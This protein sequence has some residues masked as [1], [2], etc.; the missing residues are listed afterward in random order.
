MEIKNCYD[1]IM[2]MEDLSNKLTS[3][4]E[5]NQSSGGV[6]C[7]GINSVES[8]FLVIKHSL[9]IISVPLCN[10]SAYSLGLEMFQ[11]QTE[12]NELFNEKQSE[13]NQEVRRRLGHTIDQI[14]EKYLKIKKDLAATPYTKNLKFA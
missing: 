9:D 8:E 13:I 5:K 14:E 11:Y 6:L 12:L 4:L 3:L 1:A 10:K 7:G 2:E